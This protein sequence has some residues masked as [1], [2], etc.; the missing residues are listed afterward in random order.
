MKTKII[1]KTYKYF[2]IAIVILLILTLIYIFTWYS[3]AKKPWEIEYIETWK[4]LVRG[5]EWWNYAF[6]LQD[7]LLKLWF[8]ENDTIIIINNCKKS[9]TFVWRCIKTA[10]MI[11]FA[12]SGGWKKC[13]NNSCMWL[14][15]SYKDKDLMFKD[16]IVRYNKYWYNSPLPIHYYSINWKPSKTRYCYNEAW[17]YKT[18]H[19]PN[20]LKNATYAFNLLNK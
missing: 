10:W 6:E 9:T 8:S 17:T 18:Y 19:C 2:N 20:W 15:K 13:L 7:K 4:F 14:K 1:K 11:W 16:W 12:E 3:E 5:Y